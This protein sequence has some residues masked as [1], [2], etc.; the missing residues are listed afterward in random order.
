MLPFVG[1]GIFLFLIIF[2][3]YVNSVPPKERKPKV[4]DAQRILQQNNI[5][6]FMQ[7]VDLNAAKAGG[8]DDE[9]SPSVVRSRLSAN[10]AELPRVRRHNLFQDDYNIR[11]GTDS[12]WRSA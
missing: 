3:L 10:N 8:D 7:G 11:R 9:G 1:G 4:M 12:Y 6:E 2:G 5:P